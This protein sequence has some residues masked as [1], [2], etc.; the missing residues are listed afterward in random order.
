MRAGIDHSKYLCPFLCKMSSILNFRKVDCSSNG[1]CEDGV[2]L[3]RNN[4]AGK[5]CEIDVQA[6]LDT[7]Q[8]LKK[9]LDKVTNAKRLCERQLVVLQMNSTAEVSKHEE[10]EDGRWSEWIDGHCSKSCSWEGEPAGTITR[11]R[12]CLAGV[13]E[14]ERQQPGGRSCNSWEEAP[15]SL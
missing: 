2:C 10:P 14:G 13:C 8:D 7:I 9:E 15:C 5:N 4:F 12:H 6:I 3:C 11:Y 1:F